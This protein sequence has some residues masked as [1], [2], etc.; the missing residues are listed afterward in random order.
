MTLTATEQAASAAPVATRVGS[1]DPDKFPD[2]LAKE[3][4]FEHG[5]LE[6]GYT[7]QLTAD[8]ILYQKQSQGFI[9][10]AIDKVWH[11]LLTP[12]YIY[13]WLKLCLQKQNLLD[14]HFEGITFLGGP[15]GFAW[16][17][18]FAEFK[19]QKMYQTPGKDKH[20]SPRIGDKIL[21]RGN[22][23]VFIMVYA[24]AEMNQRFGTKGWL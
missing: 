12:Y 16:H 18:I 22:P 10:F 21:I 5:G 11:T 17:Y 9:M 3:A 23:K 19:V 20:A 8:W 1:R 7:N 6:E 13:V 14:F 15:N 4:V 2:W 24:W